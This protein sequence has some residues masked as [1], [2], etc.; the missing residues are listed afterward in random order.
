[1]HSNAVQM[2]AAAGDGKPVQVFA[3]PVHSALQ[4]VHLCTSGWSGKAVPEPGLHVGT[5]WGKRTWE[6][7]GW[8]RVV[9]WEGEVGCFPGAR[10]CSLRV[11]YERARVWYWQR[12]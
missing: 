2:H 5:S 10:S 7:C 6:G 12:C 8:G 3:K 4:P 1:M 9:G 11:T